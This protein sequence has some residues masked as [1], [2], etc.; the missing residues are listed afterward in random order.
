MVKNEKQ[1]TTR[2]KNLLMYLEIKLQ[3][4]SCKRRICKLKCHKIDTNEKN[5]CKE[6][7][8]KVPFLFFG[9]WNA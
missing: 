6:A 4:A 8:T 3:Y 2:N 9:L 7:I 1:K 5:T